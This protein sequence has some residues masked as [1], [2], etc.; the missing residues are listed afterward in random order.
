LFEKFTDKARRVVV[1]AQEEAK[2]LNH[3]YI[4][5][6]HI[7]LGL[8]HEGEGVAAKA[9]EALGINLEQVREQ[10][11]DIIGQGQQSPSGHIPFTPR[12][13]KVLELSLREALQ[14]GHSYIGTEHLLLGLIREGEGVAAQ[15][16]TKLGADTNKVRQQVIQLL[17][18]YQ[19][20]E[21]VSVGGE[22]A[23]PQKGSQVLDQYGRNLSQ[24]AAEG[25]LDPVVGREREIER[26]MQILSRRTKNNPILIG[27][28]G[29]GKTAI[30]EGLAQA[31]VAGNVPE[32]LRGKQLYTLDMG[33]LIAGSRYR[34][35][36]EERLKKVTKEIRTRGDIITF[37]DEIHTLVGAGAAE[38]AIDAA[39]I[40]KPML[41]RGEL[42]TIGATTLDEY[43][44]HFE[45]DA[46]LVRRFQSV[47]VSEPTPAM[48]INILKGLR[49]RYEAHHKISI[50]DGAIVSAVGMSDRYVTD[51][52]LPDKAID[53]IDEA[54]ARVRL[55]FL[56]SPPELKEMEDKVAA[57]KA[58]KEQAIADQDFEL[59]ASKRDE[60]KKLTSEK[61]KM[62]KEF[63]E[64]NVDQTGLV[65]EGLIAEVLAQATGIPVFKLG[66]D[67]GAKL[68]FMEQELHKRVI[69]QEAA[70]AALSKTIRR[71]RAGLKDPKRPSGSFIFAGPTGVGKT[72]L[73]KALAEFL[74]DDE[75]ALIALDMSEFSEK[76]TV[77]RLF[78]APPGFVGFDE[79]GQ[80]TEKVRRKPFSVVL[81]DEIEK[82]HPDI[83]N[84]LLQILEEGRLTDGQGRVVDFKNTIII[85]TTNL[86]SR[87]ISRGAL[88]FTLEG[89]AANDYDQMK[90]RVNEELKKNF[91][92][93]FL[94]RVDEVIVFPQLTREELMQIVDLF[95][96]R[97]QQ[98]LDERDL[99]LVL[100]TGAKERLIELGYEPALGARP[101]RR[102]VQREIEDEISERI[103][104]G[105][106]QNA[107]DIKVDF[108]DGAFTFETTS[109]EAEAVKK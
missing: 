60:E 22:V 76:H 95:V 1:L 34:G 75:D 92:P 39:S 103:L 48:A 64:G 54:G 24:A 81:F 11:Q 57:V 47:L 66:E 89:D 105:D 3:N 44:K 93:E 86:G 9:L 100:T 67:E 18:G 61:I 31:I 40:L 46:A 62:E 87:E 71:Q 13:K 106:I 58:A 74:F 21:A 7:L 85:M 29:V 82:A 97:L 41:A 101:L 55:S 80:L 69:G 5:T 50:T 108:V 91:K 52:F 42:Q 99:K 109:R 4:G 102:T 56:S 26:V 78:G 28:P 107:Q 88:G 43:R 17:S 72:E 70:I 15:V 20:K 65:D 30:V 83:F 36:F 23:P 14:L 37:I 77:S 96:G 35:D 73:A 98:R 90:S 8:I 94:N 45:K 104:T 2:L 19:G 68:I 16:L 59:A 79:G 25:K 27:E 12:A 63:R 51:R 33:S 53:L 49:D 38:G 84:S 32:T 10:V 6:E